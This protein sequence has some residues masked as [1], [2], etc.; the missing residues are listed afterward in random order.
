MRT[1]SQT[2]VQSLTCNSFPSFWTRSLPSDCRHAWM[3]TNCF[4]V[5]SPGI[6]AFIPWKRHCYV[7]CRTWHQHWNRHSHTFNTFGYERCIWYCGPWASSP[8]SWCNVRHS[9]RCTHVDCIIPLGP[10]RKVHVNGYT[11]PYLSLKYGVPQGSV[12]GPLLFILY[13]GELEHIINSHGL[14][15]HCYADDCQLSFFYNPGETESPATRVINCVDDVS[16]WMSSNRLQ[17]NPTKT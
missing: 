17:V 12:L 5:I 8:P 7:F 14:L 3:I 6:G 1:T 10:Y 16:N 13:T 4:L 15:S 11:S 9:E 2:I